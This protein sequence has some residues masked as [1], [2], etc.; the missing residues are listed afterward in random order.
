MYSRFFVAKA[1]LNDNL[2]KYE[3]IG[4]MKICKYIVLLAMLFSL[5]ACQRSQEERNGI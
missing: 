1:P 4:K 2:E 5:G 3:S